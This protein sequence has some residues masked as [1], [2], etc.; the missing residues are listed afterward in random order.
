MG[1]ARSCHRQ[2]LLFR[3]V[4]CTR[5]FPAR[6]RK[7][8]ATGKT[9]EKFSGGV[10]IYQISSLGCRCGTVLNTQ[11]HVFFFFFFS[12]TLPKILSIKGLASAF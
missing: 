7:F 11:L 9:K 1:V 10:L 3:Q 5:L 4:V 6:V 8:I 2:E 12:P